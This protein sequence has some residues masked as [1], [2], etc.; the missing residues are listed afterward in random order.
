ML[1]Q[2]FYFVKMKKGDL[3]ANDMGKFDEA[4]VKGIDVTL[5]EVFEE[6]TE[7]DE[8]ISL[9]DSFK[10]FAVIGFETIKAKAEFAN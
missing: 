3:L 4:R 10:I 2:T 5:G 6:T 1:K 7:S 9:S 8:V